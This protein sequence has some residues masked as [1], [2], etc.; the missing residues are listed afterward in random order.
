MSVISFDRGVTIPMLDAMDAVGETVHVFHVD[1][2]LDWRAEVG[3]VPRG[4]APAAFKELPGL[5]D[6]RRVYRSCATPLPCSRYGS[7]PRVCRSV[8]SIYLIRRRLR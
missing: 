2:H 5:S 7:N 8:A 4:F 1:V 6:A 3:G